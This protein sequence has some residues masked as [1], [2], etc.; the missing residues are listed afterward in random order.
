[1]LV[2]LSYNYVLDLFLQSPLSLAVCHSTWLWAVWAVA[3]HTRPDCTPSHP[4]MIYD[5]DYGDNDYCDD[6][7]D[8]N[9]DDDDDDSDDDGPLWPND[10]RTLKQ[11]HTGAYRATHQTK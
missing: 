3:F 9:G 2:F 1:M 7:D 11:C 4:M 6:D 8:H 5:D 10:M